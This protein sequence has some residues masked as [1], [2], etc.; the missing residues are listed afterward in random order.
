MIGI[1]TDYECRDILKSNYLGRI[2]CSQNG[3]TYIVPVNYFFNGSSIIIHSQEGRKVKMMRK[4]PQ[5]CFQVE[6]VKSFTRWKSVITWG[7]YLEITDEKEKWDALESFVA[8][9]IH[10]KA[11][12][13]THSPE[14]SAER[15]HPRSN[16]KV[17][18]FKISINKI[19][20]RFKADE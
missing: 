3:E 1:L 17:V 14:G 7:N 6:E 15:V 20:G 5:V 11:S 9:F 13:T 19:S 18:V 8:H 4:N 10:A 16:L 2:G 12:E